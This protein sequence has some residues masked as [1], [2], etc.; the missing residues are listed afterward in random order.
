[1]NFLVYLLIIELIPLGLLIFGALCESN[2]N[3]YPN[4]KFGYKNQYSIKDKII[5]EYSNKA[6]S[7]IFGFIGT[8]LFIVNGIVLFIFSETTFS[9]ILI[10]N[11]FIL[12]FSIMIIDK[13]IKKKF[14]NKK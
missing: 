11:L 2:S 1:M 10:I 8:V 9:F 6:A 3:K 7:K 14:N 4:T 12:I 5:W 13:I